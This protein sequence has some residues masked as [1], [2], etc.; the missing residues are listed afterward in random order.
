M[1]EHDILPGGFQSRVGP[2]AESSEEARLLCAARWT[3]CENYLTR[4]HPMSTVYMFFEC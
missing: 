2:E 4:C 1:E 3:T